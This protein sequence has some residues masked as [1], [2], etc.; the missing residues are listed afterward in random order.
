[1]RCPGTVCGKSDHGSYRAVIM[2]RPTFTQRTRIQT[3]KRR[4]T[5]MVFWLGG[6][7]LL[8]LVAFLLLEPH[9]LFLREVD[10]VVMRREA[11]RVA[12]TGRGDRRT[13]E[14][15]FLLVREEDGQELEMKVDET[16]FFQFDSG[17]PVYK[18]RFSSVPREQ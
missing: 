14:R 18:P 13:E 2:D 5:R 16:V 12:V 6:L 15:Y 7:V 10:G 4:F 17:S 1:V 11:R 9:V 8:C 3:K